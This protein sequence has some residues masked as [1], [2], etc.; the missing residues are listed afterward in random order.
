MEFQQNITNDEQRPL[1]RT[2]L[3]LVRFLN[4]YFH[5]RCRKDTGFSYELWAE[6][7]GF[8]SKASVRMVCQGKRNIT[9]S[10]IQAFAKAEKLSSEDQDYLQLLNFHQK[11]TSASLKKCLLEK[12]LEKFDVSNSQKQVKNYILFLSSNQIPVVQMLISFEDFTATEKNLRETMGLDA[13]TLKQ[14]LQILEELE[15]VQKVQSEG[16][17]ESYWISKNKLFKIPG[18]ISDPAI[19]L[20][21]EQTMLEAKAKLQTLSPY[22]QYRTL[23]FSLDEEAYK[24]IYETLSATA[25]RLKAE[26]CNNYISDKRLFKFNFQLYP[27]TEKIKAKV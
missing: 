2:Y 22:N 7:L 26:Y 20:F 23:Y 1:L 12:I 3:N 6:E 19:A 10:F 11:A 24:S 15:L 13:K 8:K 21:H 18:E 9:E 5:Y 25:N 14:Y 4:D 27:V 16:S 17:A